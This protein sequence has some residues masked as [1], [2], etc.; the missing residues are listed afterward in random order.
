MTNP[1]PDALLAPTVLGD[2]HSHVNSTFE[3]GWRSLAELLREDSGI[4]ARY[5]RH[6]V[7]RVVKDLV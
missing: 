7:L 6:V 4:E 2:T 3:N 5:E 1:S